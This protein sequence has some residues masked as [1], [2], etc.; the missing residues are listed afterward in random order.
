MDGLKRLRQFAGG[1]LKLWATVAILRAKFLRG[2][3]QLL[4][5]SALENPVV[6]RVTL[7]PLAGDECIGCSKVERVEANRNL[8]ALKL[9]IV[10]G[11]TP[12]ENVIDL[13]ASPRRHQRSPLGGAGY[14]RDHEVAIVG[15]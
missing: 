11:V 4:L 5:R 15:N 13:N 7:D 12:V 6:I 14:G 2:D 9:G 3:E 8:L 1:D 10:H